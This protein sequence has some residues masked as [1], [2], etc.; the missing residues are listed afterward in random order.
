LTRERASKAG[1]G[2][3]WLGEEDGR[4]ALLVDGVVQSVAPRDRDDQPGY[5]AA[6]LPS[7]R[8]ARSLLLGLGGGT[9]VHLLRYRFGPTPIVAVDDD[10]AL[11]AFA[12]TTLGIGGPG[13][14]VVCADAFDYVAHVEGRFDYVAVDLYRGAVM[15]H[16]V[17]GK[18]FLRR[19]R[20]LTSPGGLVAV[21]LFHSRRTPDAL[22][23]IGKVFPRV[24]PVV[25][26][27]NCVAR[28]RPR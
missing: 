4:P 25:V 23:R 12:L 14:E 22:R 19:L 9:L 18:P 8:P 7:A 26:G 20:A 21:N 15:S 28:C 16:G 17:L 11:I 6:M 24:D 5:W 3:I 2:Q 27:R 1:A 13:L 10:A